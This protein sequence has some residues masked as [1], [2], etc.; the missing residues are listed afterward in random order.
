MK[1]TKSNFIAATIIIAV[2]AAPKLAEQAQENNFN[3]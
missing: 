2:P 3:R 1:S